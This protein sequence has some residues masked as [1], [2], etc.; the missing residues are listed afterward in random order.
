M[1]QTNQTTPSIIFPLV[2]SIIAISFAAIF[3]KWS[4]AP[5]TILSMYRMLMASALLVPIVWKKRAEFQKLSR[6]D[7]LLLVC[8]GLF[9][10]LHFALWFGSLKLTTVASS[11]I[12]LALQP[13]V[14]LIGGFLLY[15]ERVAG[16]TILM[17][18]IAFVGVVMVG[19]GDITVGKMALIGDVL[20]FLCVIAVVCYLLIGQ[21]VVKKF[22]HWVY[23]FSVF[24]IAGLFLALYNVMAGIPLVDYPRKEWG[25][26]FLLA[27]FPTLAHLI[28]NWLL[29]YVNS[30]TIS[31]TILGEPVGA[32]ILAAILLKEQITE[33]QI[34]G[35]LLVLLGVFFFLIKQRKRV[36]YKYEG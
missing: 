4:S 20:S 8:S 5:S 10:A 22:S 27:I 1:K 18:M 13:L 25:I 28:Y 16:S 19:W 36:K 33:W 24:L 2:I 17:M 7:W 34:L 29:N 26:F 23:S 9:L 21:N 6:K 3:V 15:K 14:A 12:I 32:T 30:T 31:M 11:T 35:G